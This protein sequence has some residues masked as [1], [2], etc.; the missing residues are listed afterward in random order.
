MQREDGQCVGALHRAALL[1]QQTFFDAARRL[2]RHVLELLDRSGGE[3]I[4][5][6]RDDWEHLVF[7]A[8]QAGFQGDLP[9]EPL[10]GRVL[11]R[12]ALP[13]QLLC[14]CHSGQKHELRPGDHQQGQGLHRDSRRIQKWRRLFREQQKERA[15]S[16]HPRGCRDVRPRWQRRSEVRLP[17]GV[18]KTSACE[19]PGLRWC[20]GGR[21]RDRGPGLRELNEPAGGTTRKPLGSAPRRGRENNCSQAH[22]LRLLHGGAL[23]RFDSSYRLLLLRCSNKHHWLGNGHWEGQVHP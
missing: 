13:V 17:A 20:G 23:H 11:A 15:N 22:L 2:R 19:H 5:L 18:R 8:W 1:R 14:R 12:K 7:G 4:L 21:W 10:R 16:Q 6:S 9:R 3:C